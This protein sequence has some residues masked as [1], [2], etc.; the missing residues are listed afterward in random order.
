[1]VAGVVL[2]NVAWGGK[3]RLAVTTSKPETLNAQ[4]DVA[5]CSELS[6]TA[7]ADLPLHIVRLRAAPP[8]TTA[9]GPIRFQ[10][11]L[12]NPNLGTL[13]ADQD[14][15]MGE[16]AAVIHALCAELGN[17]C[18]LTEEQLKLYD[19]PTILWI[20]PTCEKALPANA[21]KRYV[22]G[23][24][25][26][27]VR[28]F[29]GNKKRGKGA[30]SV[31]YGRTATATLAVNN[32]TGLGKVVPAGLEALFSSS[33]DPMGVS[34]PA[35]DSH[36]FSNG[37]ADGGSVLGPSLQA[38]T[39]L[40]YGSAGKH[41]GTLTVHLHDGS[42]LCDNIFAKVDT[43]DNHMKLD[44]KTNP[45]PGLFK[46]GDPRTGNVTLH[47]LVKNV[48]DPSVAK[49]VILFKGAGVLSC[50]TEIR[51]GDSTLSKTT[52]IDFQHCSV[53]L[54][55]ACGTDADCA[56]AACPDCQ[57]A[58]TCLGSSHCAFTGFGGLDVVGCV[59]DGDCGPGGQ[60][61]LVVPVQSLTLAIGETTE[62]LTSRIPVANTLPS[63][64]KIVET[65]TVHA[66][67]APDD[68]D[69]VKY[70][71]QSNPAVQP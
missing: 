68:T 36:E 37:D 14:I 7:D 66:R 51:V 12:P 43:S 19:K 34:L 67:N 11:S 30:V 1:M 44:V 23:Q 4:T 22:G 45:T 13:V 60:C 62:L 58:E 61:I 17:E 63:T 31:G 5:N 38:S 24:V 15:P 28:A 18:Q 10:W 27:G 48:S 40:D 35:I 16:Q 57:A 39:V 6:K 54:D 50:D 25:T 64:A 9:G 32:Q 65:W 49:G 53:T 71:I 26:V 56:P 46:P 21:L 70:S 41:T 33:V 55:Q 20:A 29:E 59:R 8:T 52:Q 47:V 42:A 2:A 3:A 69:V